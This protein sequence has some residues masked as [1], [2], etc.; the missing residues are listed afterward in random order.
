MPLGSSISSSLVGR[1]EG[2]TKPGEWKTEVGFA[3][4]GRRRLPS[5]RGS[6][7]LG[8]SLP[9]PLL[10]FLL[11]PLPHSPP[12]LVSS[13]PILSPMSFDETHTR[14][15]G[16]DYPTATPT[17][18]DPQPYN[19]DNSGDGPFDPGNTPPLVFAFIAIGFVT[20]GLIVAIIYKKFRL[21][22]NPSEPNYQRSSVPIRR[23]L[24]QKP[25]LWDIRIAPSKPVADEERENVGDW[26]TFVVS[27][28][29]IGASSMIGRDTCPSLCRHHLY[30]LIRALHP[31]ACPNNT[32]K[33]TSSDPSPWRTP[34][35]GYSS[36]TLQ[37]T[38]A[39]M[40]Q[41]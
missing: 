21:L 14:D 6:W 22:Q 11:S 4:H 36:D 15:L 41:S 13:S 1:R 9:F 3:H 25:E 5:L 39:S 37:Q 24:A 35:T 7:R 40:S 16:P 27:C 31:F 20:F 17:W 12:P 33:A 32:S 23:P 30:I 26:D 2:S 10:I 8:G 34:N 28:T 19:T 18:S 38:Q 29:F